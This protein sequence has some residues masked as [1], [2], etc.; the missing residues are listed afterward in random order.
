MQQPLL[1]V[2]KW[3]ERD[4]HTCVGG[5][6]ATVKRCSRVSSKTRGFLI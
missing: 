6:K 4:V 3:N 2:I 1:E 5:W